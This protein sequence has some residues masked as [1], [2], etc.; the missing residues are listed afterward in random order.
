MAM[1]PPEVEAATYALV[2]EDRWEM[3]KRKTDVNLGTG[4]CSV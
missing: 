4:Y 1:I 3:E 2:A